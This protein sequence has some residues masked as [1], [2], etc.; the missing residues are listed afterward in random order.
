M[1]SSQFPLLN[2]HEITAL[3]EALH[4][5][6]MAE[7]KQTCELLSLPPIGKKGALIARIVRYIQCGEITNLPH[8]PV[9]SRAPHY[10]PQ[11]LAPSSLMLSGSYKNDLKTREFFKKLIGP[12]FHFTAFGIDWLTERWYQGNPPTYQEFADFWIEENTR[13][14][15]KKEKPKDEWMF[16]RF[17]QTVEKSAPNASLAERQDLWKKVQSQKAEEAEQLVKKAVKLLP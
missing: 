17:M 14:K 15:R 2:E 6:K 7:L 9:Q 13:R 5:C 1:H 11:P 16:I 3:T 4:Y 10:P 8:I 12:H